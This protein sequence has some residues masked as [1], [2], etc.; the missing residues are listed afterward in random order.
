M[1][2][3]LHLICNAH[4]DP[5]WLWEW[6]E[7]VAAAVATFRTAADLCEQFD[8][9]VFNHNEAILY[10]WVEEY[11]P[12]LFRRIQKL[13]RAKKWHIMGGWYLQPDCN[14]PSGESFVR[15]ILIG[16]EYFQKK[17]AAQP[18]TAINFDPFGHTR[19]LVQILA[20]SGYDSY[21]FCRPG[22]ETC[23]LPAE[24]FVWV[25][26]DGSQIIGIRATSHYNSQLGEARQKIENWIRENPERSVG[27]VLWGVGNHGGGP[28][29]EDLQN[30]ASLMA[31]E[32][33]YHI[34]HST[35][36]HYVRDLLSQ[37]K[38]LPRHEKDINPWAVGCYT[39]MARI[40]QRHRRLENEY[41]LT[42][43]M[44]SFAALNGLMAYPRAELQEALKDLLT[45]QFHD[46]L[47]G[48]SI[49]PV[50]G[51]ALRL[52]D[53]GLEILS[54]VK[55]R[56]F[57]A[58]AAGQPEA[59]EEEI[60]ILV[61]NPH[62]F[63]VSGIFECEFQLARENRTG[64][65]TDAHVHQNGQPLPTQVEKELSNLNMDWRKRVVFYASLA[66][67]QMSR[68][69]ARLELL[70]QKPAVRLMESDHRIVFQTEEM[71]VTINTETGFVNQYRVHGVDY[72]KEGAFRPV[73][74]MDN[75]D[76]WG[77]LVTSFRQVAG[78]FSLMTDDEVRQFAD[79][80][81]PIKPVRVIEDGDV[82]SVIEV[83][84]KYGQSV[85]WQRYKLPKRGTEIEIEIRVL[86]NE[87]DR[88]LKLMVPTL[89]EDGEF[90]GQVAYGVDR[91]PEDGAEAVAQKWL[92][93]VSPERNL[94]IS[95]INDGTYG[96]DFKDGE[97]RLSLLRS[98]AYAA[99]PISNRDI[100]PQDRYT[101]RMDQGEH[102]FR[103]W[104]NAGQLQDRMESID[105]EALVKNEKPFV[106]SFFPSGQGK[107][108]LPGAVLSDGVVQ[109]TAIKWAEDGDALIV[110]LYEPTGQRRRTTISIPALSFALEM[111]LE[112]F[113]IKT[114]RIDL[115]NGKSAF[116]DL[117]E[118]DE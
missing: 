30:I 57:F 15:Q 46:I 87:K 90:H 81:S 27:L 9:F 69:D 34:V 110:R 38:T 59:Q 23:H 73:V 33:S 107:P 36:E 79:L 7:G 83:G 44:A 89:F 77:T 94:A 20:K 28:S 109:I 42:E 72:L 60:P 96:S 2:R 93:V 10:Q 113:E 108:P 19:G 112:K 40:K 100:I 61:Y 25:G 78:E 84:L 104:F 67:G 6:E 41:F 53:H 114:L 48:S 18:T 29:R 31:E 70:P 63:P 101:P 39:S 50:E 22:P 99:L 21:L 49:Q 62:P 91:L 16:K 4:I 116:V 95:A 103:F 74:I 85:I 76:S 68:F 8:T 118:N 43:K 55:A 102:L 105:R 75:E 24:E 106:L 115:L 11:D 111:T 17:F 14:M 13:V 12:P 5:V 88:M 1:T 54:R 26:Y 58:L 82:R 117:L 65:F 45:S 64:S 32:K 98:P 37:H 3:N 35:P 66:P 92:A 71:Q 56:A 47:P 51:S 97:L 52:M 86:W 80:S